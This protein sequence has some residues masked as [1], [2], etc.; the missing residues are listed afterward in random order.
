MGR[1]LRL[2]AQPGNRRSE[3]SQ[4]GTRL[5]T[6]GT[7]RLGSSTAREC[8]GVPRY[9][10]GNARRFDDRKAISR[11]DAGLSEERR[12]LRQGRRVAARRRADAGGV[13]RRRRPRRREHVCVHRSG[14]PGVDRRRARALRHAQARRARWSSPAAW[15]S[16][17]A[18]SSRPRCPKPTRSW[19][20][21]TKARWSTSCCG[22][23]SRREC[24]TCS[25]CRG[26]RRARPGRT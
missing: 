21:R 17:T 19:G 18:T 13:R 2:R 10:G 25:S 8:T 22:A 20:S 23:A 24:A 26:R 6:T 12:R 3:C 11:R 16:A 15:P 14:A 7:T 1:L 5:R 4:L 9:D